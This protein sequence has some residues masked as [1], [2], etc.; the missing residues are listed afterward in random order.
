MSIAD[1]L[2]PV[3][4]LSAPKTFILKFCI[5]LITGLVAHRYAKINASSDRSYVIKWVLISSAC[6]LGFNVIFDPI[7]GYFYK[8]YILGQPQELAAVLARI[9]ALTTFVNAVVS[10]ILVSVISQRPGPSSQA[11]WFLAAERLG[12][13]VPQKILSQLLVPAI[14]SLLTQA[15]TFASAGREVHPDKTCSPEDSKMVVNGAL[16]QTHLPGNFRKERGPARSLRILNRFSSAKAL[17]CRIRS[18]GTSPSQ[19]A[20]VRQG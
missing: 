10:V 17:T 4:V 1:L 15:I 3:Y 5:G 7:V 13:S 14:Q 9:S 2:D 18:A 20:A 11:G 8:Q 12:I 16:R 6:G 19:N